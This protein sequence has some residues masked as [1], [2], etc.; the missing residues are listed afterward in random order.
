MAAATPRSRAGRMM[1]YLF[2]RDALIGLASLMLLVISGYAAWHGMRDFI[3]GTG[4]ST[5]GNGS[6]STE[7]LVIAVVVALTFLMWLALRETFGSQRRLKERL[8]TFPLYLFLAIWSVGFGYGFW[9]SLISGEETTRTGLSGLQE[10]ARDASSVVAARLDSV[11][12]QLD[13][14]VG[15]SESQMTREEKTGGSCGTS[16]NAGRGPLY[17]ARR[18]VRDS[19]GTMRDGMTKSWFAPVLSDVEQLRQSAAGLSGATVGERQKS[20]ETE[21]SQI[22]GKARNIAARSNE[23]GR[24]YAGEM[25]VLAD[26][27]SIA[28][29]TSGFSCYDSMLAQRLRQGATEAEQP[30]QLQLRDAAFNEGPAGV[31]NAI[32]KRFLQNVS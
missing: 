24:S 1:N 31:A 6:L 17:N 22:R 21:A 19:V 8:I 32:K 14:V 18:N 26:T 3:L 27:V 5:A 28:P 25:R 23:L 7:I 10:D 13:S 2:G 9:W 4:S 12:S 11:R 15:W 20:F 30:A 16:S 29:G